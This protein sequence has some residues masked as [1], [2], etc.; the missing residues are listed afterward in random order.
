[1]EGMSLRA[2]KSGEKHNS[3]ALTNA[4]AEQYERR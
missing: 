2:C 4:A 1:M 3:H